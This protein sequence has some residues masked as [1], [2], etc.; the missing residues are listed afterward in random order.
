[1]KINKLVKFLKENEISLT[2]PGC[3]GLPIDVFISALEEIEKNGKSSLIKLHREWTYGCWEIVD[4]KVRLYPPSH[5]EVDR[6]LK[7]KEFWKDDED[8]EFLKNFREELVLR[9]KIFKSYQYK[10]KA[11]FSNKLKNK[12]KKRDNYRCVKCG[13][14]KELEIDHIVPLIKGGK[15]LLKNLQTLCRKCHSLKTKTDRE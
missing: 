15:N 6:L 5:R 11:G 10:R 14:D 2:V 4:Y 8:V 12:C 3:Y 7:L 13:L 9:E 1:M